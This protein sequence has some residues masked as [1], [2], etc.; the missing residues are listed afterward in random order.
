MPKN[1]RTS[2]FRHNFPQKFLQC[3][4]KKTLIGHICFSYIYD[5]INNIIIHLSSQTKSINLKYQNKPL[6]GRFNIFL[7]LNTKVS[8]LII[9]FPLVGVAMDYRPV[10]FVSFNISIK[11]M[12]KVRNNLY[13]F[14]CYIWSMNGSYATIQVT[15]CN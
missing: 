14:S 9:L 7:A 3:L 8:W 2:C 4:K 5:I 1:D 13:R 11:A 15:I 10:N 12:W 6:T